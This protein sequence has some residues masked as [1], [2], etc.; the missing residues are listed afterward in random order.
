MPNQNGEGNMT[1]YQN[2]TGQPDFMN[3]LGIPADTIPAMGLMVFILVINSCLILLIVCHSSLRTTSNIILASLAV[4]DFLVGFIGIPLLVACSSTF[5]APV[6]IS[7]SIFFKFI[8]LSTVLHITVI[9]CD[10]YFY[11]VWA[12]HYSNIVQRRRVLIILVSIWIISLTSLVRLSWTLT[13][14][15]IHSAR[16]DLALVQKSETTYFLFNFIVFFFIPLLVMI[17]L[18]T[19]MIFLLRT[20]YRRIARENLPTDLVKHEKNIQRLQRRAVFICILLLTLYVIFWLPYF[21]L[22]LMLQNHPEIPEYAVITIYY[23]RL[24]PSLFNPLAYTF[25]K[26]DLKTK[27]KCF[28]RKISS[29]CHMEV[30]SKSSS[31]IKLNSIVQ[32]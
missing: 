26:Q 30:P 6:C 2:E 18:D 9:T 14:T 15:D 17:F 1:G 7:S 32:V 29:Y 24:C 31:E 3:D 21:I 23:L 10:R 27:A 12:L 8:S 19:H 25:R 13:V 11:I 28:L 5:R 22:E 4:S 16:E 20:Q